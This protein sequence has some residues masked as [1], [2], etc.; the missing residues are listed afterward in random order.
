MTPSATP[1]TTAGRALA[2]D[3]VMMSAGL[4]ELTSSMARA[5]ETGDLDAAERLLADRGRLLQRIGATPAPRPSTLGRA[6]RAAADSDRQSRDGLM[7][8]IAELRQDLAGLAVGAGALR[9]YGASSGLAPG[10]V[11]RRD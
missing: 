2:S 3:L 5:I 9:A 6:A 1:D 4:A 7:R 8:R 10:F 11:D